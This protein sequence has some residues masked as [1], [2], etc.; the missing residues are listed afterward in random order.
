MS[1]TYN[2]EIK[3]YYC[4]VM[5]KDQFADGWIGVSKDYL[6]DSIKELILNDSSIRCSID[7]HEMLY[8]TVDDRFNMKFEIIPKEVWMPL[9]KKLIQLI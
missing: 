7:L 5:D 6:F 1:E 9:Y 3:K 2:S 8:G 4:V